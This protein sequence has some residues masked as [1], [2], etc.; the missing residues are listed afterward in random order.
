MKLK[1]MSLSLI[2]GGNLEIEKLY[3]KDLRETNYVLVLFKKNDIE[4]E[5][6]VNKFRSELEIQAMVADRYQQILKEK[7]NKW[8]F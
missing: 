8:V 3:T 4:I 1:I 5:F 6:I 2:E 7:E